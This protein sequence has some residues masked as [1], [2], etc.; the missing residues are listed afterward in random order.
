MKRLR[1]VVAMAVA[2]AALTASVSAASRDDG[3]WFASSGIEESVSENFEMWTMMADPKTKKEVREVC[4]P[5]SFTFDGES[6]AFTEGYKQVRA[7][8][9]YGTDVAEGKYVCMGWF[10]AFDRYTGLSFESAGAERLGVSVSYEWS[11][12]KKLRSSVTVVVTC[13]ADYDGTMF[14]CGYEDLAINAAWH[15]LDPANKSYRIDEL[16]YFGWHGDRYY[17]FS[18]SPR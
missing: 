1:M 16:P 14:Y 5:V 4:I 17:F 6:P 15:Q 11:S 3:S 9:S 10:S 12:E 7:T 2:L 13:P 18:G 8:F